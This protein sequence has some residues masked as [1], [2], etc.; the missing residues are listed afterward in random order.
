[1][2]L[3]VPSFYADELGMPL[4]GVGAAIAASRL[5]DVVTDP[6]IGSLSDRLPTRWG[7]RK[8]WMTLAAPL[9]LG[10]VWRRSRFPGA[11]A[12]PDPD[13]PHAPGLMRNPLSGAALRR[14]IRASR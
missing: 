8:P 14:I 12:A 2:A 6:L 3:L 13:R 5:L 9:F 11:G 10:A 7:R 4:A 1:M